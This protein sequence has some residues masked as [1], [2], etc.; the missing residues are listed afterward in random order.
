[1]PNGKNHS[2]GTIKR[3]RRCVVEKKM[4]VLRA[5]EITKNVSYR[6]STLARAANE[7]CVARCAGAAARPA[8]AAISIIYFIS[9]RNVELDQNNKEV[10]LR[11]QIPWQLSIIA[12]NGTQTDVN[13]YTMWR[14]LTL[15]STMLRMSSVCGSLTDTV[16]GSV[17]SQLILYVQKSVLNPFY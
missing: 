14:L 9:A 3:N 10:K 1:M 6:G 13:K 17:G 16:H 4:Q 11:V 5:S 8:R 2:M 12:L 15:R 7:Y